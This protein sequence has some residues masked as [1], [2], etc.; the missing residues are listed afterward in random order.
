MRYM[1]MVRANADSEAD[2]KPS[3]EL[4]AE[5]AD[6]HQELAKAGALRDASGLAPSSRGWRIRYSEGKRTVVDGPYAE[7]KELIA[8][9][10]IID[11]K[12][13]EEALEWT[14]RFPNPFPNSPQAEIE[15][16][17]MKSLD[18]LGQSEAVERFRRLGVPSQR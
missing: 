14:K 16:R 1:I 3:E 4:M 10:T 15:V 6:Y 9:Y 5:M 11:V 7:A 8:G 17:P 13:E 2:G 18:E 12:S